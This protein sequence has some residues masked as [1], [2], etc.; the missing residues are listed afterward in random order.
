MGYMNSQYR[1]VKPAR[2]EQRTSYRHPVEIRRTAIRPHSKTAKTGKLMDLSIYGCRVASDGIFTEGC[3]V[4]LRFE[5]SNPIT[6]IA[7]WCRDGDVGCRFDEKLDPALFRSLTL[8][9]E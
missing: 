1:A 7:M 5:G 8:I 4:W 3:R 2:I 9:S 6:A